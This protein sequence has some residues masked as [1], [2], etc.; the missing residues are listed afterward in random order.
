MRYGMVPDPQHPGSFRAQRKGSSEEGGEAE[1]PITPDRY[2]CSHC[3]QPIPAE[4][5]IRI[6]AER[7]RAPGNS[8]VTRGATGYMLITHVCAC[9]SLAL[10]S[11]RYRSYK[12]F[13]TMFGHGVNL[14]YQSPFRPE[15]VGEDHAALQSWRWELE[16]TT[17]VEDFLYWLE[18]RRSG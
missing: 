1:G 5:V 10:T 13:L 14:P 3:E 6:E 12:A 18:H 15:I 16:Q 7:G 17:D 8:G 4:L 9:S 2:C 11:R